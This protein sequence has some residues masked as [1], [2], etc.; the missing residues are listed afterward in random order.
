MN[1]RDRIIEAADALFYAGSVREVSVDKV[2]EQAGLTKKT[3]YYHFRSKDELI[4]AYLEARHQPTVERYQ[5]WAGRDGTMPERVEN[6]FLALARAVQNDSWRGCGFI[7]VAVELADSPGHPALD[8]ARRHKASFEEWLKEDLSRAGYKDSGAAA[9]VVMVLLDGAVARML[10]NRD[11]IYATDAGHAARQLLDLYPM[12][13][14]E[15]KQQ[16]LA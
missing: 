5:Y 7:R 8:V 3:L 16:L 2:A 9:R 15:P 13:S 4:A 10:I 6:M 14:L 11:P 1:T 12:G